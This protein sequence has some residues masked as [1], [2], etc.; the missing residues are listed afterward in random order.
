VKSCCINNL[1]FNLLTLS[2]AT[3]TLCA[4]TRTSF[5]ESTFVVLWHCTVSLSVI[6]LIH[7]MLS[8]TARLYV[9][10]VGYLARTDLQAWMHAQYDEGLNTSV[11]LDEPETVLET[12]ESV[13]EQQNK[14][15]DQLS[16]VQQQ[17]EA[18]LQIS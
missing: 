10:Y 15:M 18:E 6:I 17:L 9:R 12:I 7:L 5:C 11:E 8:L 1:T 4:L 13:K 14:V 2:T 16:A 3:G